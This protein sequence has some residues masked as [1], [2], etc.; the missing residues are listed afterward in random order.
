LSEH[1][2]KIAEDAPLSDKE[3]KFILS[4][5]SS[6]GG[7]ELSQLDISSGVKIFAQH[8]ERPTSR[9]LNAVIKDHWLQQN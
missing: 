8:G 2:L 7:E 6:D 9:E 5:N 4:A 1:G 3:R